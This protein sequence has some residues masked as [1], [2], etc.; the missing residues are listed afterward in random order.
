MLSRTAGITSAQY[1][2]FPL[3]N[4]FKAKDKSLLNCCDRIE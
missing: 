3:F 4:K 1:L 2:E